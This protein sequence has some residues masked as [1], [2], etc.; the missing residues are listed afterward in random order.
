MEVDEGAAD[1]ST[2]TGG[3]GPSK[4]ET[5]PVSDVVGIVRPI[6]SEASGGGGGGAGSKET[7]K[8]KDL[9][10]IVFD[11]ASTTVYGK[12]GVVRITKAS[13]SH[14]LCSTSRCRGRS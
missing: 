10:E 11:A 1:P 8:V 3:E 7:F 2:A 4:I 9:V 5:F 12:S 13:R 14:C 6:R